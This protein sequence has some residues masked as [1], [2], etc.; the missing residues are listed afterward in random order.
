MAPI[1]PSET[2]PT[3]DSDAMAASSSSVPDLNGAHDTELARE[4]ENLLLSVCEDCWDPCK[5]SVRGLR[6]SDRSV[7][8][9]TVCPACLNAF[10]QSSR[11]LRENDVFPDLP[12]E[13]ASSV[14]ADSLRTPFVCD[15]LT[16]QID[17]VLAE[18]KAVAKEGRPVLVNAHIGR[19]DFRKGSISM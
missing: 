17:A 18:A 11:L 14:P 6:G 12:N 2:L 5:P 15:L 16:E 19:S 3:Q 1:T 8:S 4:L 7:R 10:Q 13:P 9:T